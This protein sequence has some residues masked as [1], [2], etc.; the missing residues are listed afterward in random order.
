MRKLG[1]QVAGTDY[2]DVYV[3]KCK[4]H[5]LDVR[6]GDLQGAGLTRDWSVAYLGDVVEHLRDPIAMLVDVV[7]H[8]A[9]GG[10]VV[11]RTPNAASGFSRL[12]CWWNRLT[13]TEWL[14]SEAPWHI[15]DFTPRSLRALFTSAGLDVLSEVTEGRRPF[16]YTVGA[17]GMLDREKARWKQC[18]SLG[19]RRSLL[20]GASLRI[21][22]AASWAAPPF[23]LGRLADY[24]SGA[25]DYIVLFGAKPGPRPGAGGQS[26]GQATGDGAGT[27]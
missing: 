27:P 10:I 8:L 9:P 21:A 6:R 1:W 14:S 17:S 26:V 4:A 24:C 7:A 20:F 12:S 19:E 25:A 5:G 11:A 3:E 2:S 16:G 15:N 13:G 18:R 22:A 23:V